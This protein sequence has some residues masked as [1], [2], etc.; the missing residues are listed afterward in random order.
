METPLANQARRGAFALIRDALTGRHEDFT[1]GSVRQAIVLLAIPMVLEMMMESVFA[2]ADIFFVSSLGP[3]AVAAVGLTEASVTLLFAVAVG[4]SMATTAMVARRIGERDSE[5]AATAAVQALWIGLG[6]SLLVGAVG[7]FFA[8]DVLRLMGAEQRV[9]D[10]G[11]GYTRVILGGS[12]TIT[13]LFLINA[14]FRGAGDAALSMRVLW[15]ANGINLV[16]DPCLIF[17]VGPFPELGVTGAAVATTIGRGTG[18]LVQL[19]C[20]FGGAG[21]IRVSLESLRAVPAVMLRL[22]RLSMGGIMQFLI[23]TSSWIGLVRI[24]SSFGSD[25]VA[26]YTIAIRVVMFTIL[27][28]WG[29]SN[30]AATLVGQSLGAGKPDR[31]EATV[32]QA[33]RYNIAFLVAV[34][35]GF[36]FG[37]PHILALFTD[38]AVVAGY[39]IA[40]LRALAFGYPLYGLGMIMVQAFNGAGDTD[41]PTVINFFCFW[42]FQIPLAYTLAHK[43]H[44][45]PQGVFWAVVI[46]E[47]VMTVVAVLV[48]RRGKWKNKVV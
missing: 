28:A 22:A 7:I 1:S 25:P 4:L 41:T 35:I 44:L 9:I 2:V 46:A 23:S 39:G 29:L 31:A 8:P 30:A 36:Y 17:G 13:F 27:P 5:G 47:S 38:D 3:D 24:V 37:A 21:R 26:G 42:M 19:W 12:L 16:L 6:V 34:G 14:I 33:A 11:V 48:F 18:V 15:I 20:L 10:G 40:C 43:V 45:G 32:W